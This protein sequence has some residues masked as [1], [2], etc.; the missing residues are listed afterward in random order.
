M[1]KKG[2]RDNNGHF[3]RRNFDCP[4]AIHD[5]SRY[6]GG[7][8][9]ADQLYKYYCLQR[10]SSKWTKKLFW[11]LLELM[12][13]NAFVMFNSKQKKKMT[14]Y[15]FSLQ[16]IDQIIAETF[17]I[18]NL[19]RLISNQTN[20]L[21]TL[22]NRCLPGNLSCKSYCR[23]CYHRERKWPCNEEKGRLSTVVIFAEFVCV[24][25]NVSGYPTPLKTLRNFYWKIRK[26][27][28]HML[29]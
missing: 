12:K 28:V 22:P 16:L 19:P 5:Y 27:V 13:L 8:D 23:V 14:L 26:N 6:M 11:Y 18:T 20:I 4:L 7:V 3:E 1:F 10:K 2:E 9:L 29:R 15:D 24:Y 17:T 25:L 21:K